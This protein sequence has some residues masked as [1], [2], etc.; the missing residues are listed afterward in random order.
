[1]VLDNDKYTINIVN[2]ELTKEDI[3]VNYQP[4]NTV[5]YYTYSVL[6]DGHKSEAIK[7]EGNSVATIALIESGQYTIEFINYY[8]D[9]STETFTTGTY[10]IDKEA[11]VLEIKNGKISLEVGNKFNSKKGVSAYD[12]VSGDIT[13]KITTN[14]NELNFSKLGE[15]KLVYEVRDEAGNTTKKEIIVEI[16]PSTKGETAIRQLTG[17][18][19]LIVVL[20]VIL[21]YYRTIVIEKRIGKFSIEPKNKSKNIFEK[22]LNTTLGIVE[23]FAEWLARYRWIEKYSKRY[24]RYQI[25]FKEKNTVVIV[26]KKIIISIMFFTLSILAFTMEL[27]IMTLFEMIASL[28]VG[29]YLLDFIYLFK[30]RFYRD[31]V[32]ND[33]LQAIVIMN[34]AFKSGKSIPQAIEVVSKELEGGIAIE[35]GKMKNELSMGLS[36]ETV[37][38]RFAERIEINEISYLTSSLMIL[39]QTGGNIIKVFTSIE[40]SLMNK[41][42]LR[43]ELKALTSG[44]KTV[45]YILV[46][47]PIVFMLAIT[48]V[49]PDYFIPLVDNPLGLL[50]L[51]VIILIYLLYTYIVRMIMKVRM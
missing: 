39:N 23:V 47:L 27:E 32:E 6:K 38:D 30:Y 51:I 50:I 17:L 45:T 7:V 13:S 46:L 22:F 44:A 25:A 11:P 31:N 20:F 18:G 15:K 33:L 28:L 2:H 3:I 19:I 8:K 26:A 1:M 10:D 48:V 24:E 12:N 4:K 16:I 34:N 40:R 43:L 41:K 49:S 29:F 37:F 5:S 14:E 42:K 35:F 9:G 21:G 36:V